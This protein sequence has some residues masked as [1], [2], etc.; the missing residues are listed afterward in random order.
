MGRSWGK[1]ESM[2][3]EFDAFTAPIP[4]KV[5]IALSWEGQLGRGCTCSASEW[6]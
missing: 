5:Q 6:L 3:T 1:W 2:A 4:L